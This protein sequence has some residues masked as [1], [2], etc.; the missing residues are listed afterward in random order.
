MTSIENNEFINIKPKESF[1]V[2]LQITKVS[3]PKPRDLDGIEIAELENFSRPIKIDPE[4]NKQV[5]EYL[6]KRKNLMERLAK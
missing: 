1:K 5:E 4:F 3:K 2:D 6:E